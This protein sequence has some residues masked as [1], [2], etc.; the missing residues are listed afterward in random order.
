MPNIPLQGPPE[1]STASPIG[2]IAATVYKT[3]FASNQLK[4]TGNW[5][6]EF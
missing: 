5:I 4:L 6:P 3:K 1:D 2:Y